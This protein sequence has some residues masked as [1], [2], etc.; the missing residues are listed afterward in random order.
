MRTSPPNAKPNF[1]VGID[2]SINGPGFA[3]GSPTREPTVRSF[4]HDPKEPFGNRIIRYDA[5]SNLLLAC[6]PIMDPSRCFICL[7]DYSAG[8]KGRTNEIAEMTGIFKHKMIFQYSIPVYNIRLINIQ[9]IKMF[10]GSPGNAKKELILKQVYKKYGFDTDNNDEA[11]AF[12]LWKIGQA[13]NGF[14]QDLTSHQ[15]NILEKIKE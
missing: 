4:K 13:L 3:F 8:S 2:L 9:H 5:K 6:I 14:A 7:E 11:D 10:A 15:E 1:I 12:L